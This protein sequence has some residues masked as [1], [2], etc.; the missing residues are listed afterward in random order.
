MSDAHEPMPRSG[1][2]SWLDVMPAIPLARGVPVV[3]ITGL[4]RGVRGVVV[5]CPQRWSADPIVRVAEDGPIYADAT[6][7]IPWAQDCWR[8]DLDDAHGVA[9]VL[10]WLADRPRSTLPR[11]IPSDLHALVDRW[12]LANVDDADRLSLARAC[13]EAV[14]S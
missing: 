5:A 12:L 2:A 3:V 11:S 14:R 13:A 9:H 8:V 7:S 4:R 6:T 10:R 1:A